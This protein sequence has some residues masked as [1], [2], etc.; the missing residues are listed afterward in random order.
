M[1]RAVD[2]MFGGGEGKANSIVPA[3][4]SVMSDSQALDVSTGADEWRAAYLFSQR[5][6]QS[7]TLCVRPRQISQQGKEHERVLLFIQQ[8]YSVPTVLGLGNKTDKSLCSW[9]FHSFCGR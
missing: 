6:G 7:V 8:T 5:M 2:V 3:V 4:G 9:V 1:T